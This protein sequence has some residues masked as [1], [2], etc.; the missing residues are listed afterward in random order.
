MPHMNIARTIAEV[1]A[2]VGAARAAGSRVGFVPTMGALHRAHVSLIDA[3][4]RDGAYTVV[5]IFVN[6]TQF[7]PGDDYE[8]YPRTEKQDLDACA[9]AGVDLVFLPGV[10][11]MY[12]PGSVTHIHVET[13]TEHLCGPRRPGHF[14]GVATVV[15]KLFNIVQPD[16]AYF[17]EKDL[18]QLQVIRRMV[19]DLD[20]PITIVGCPTIREPDGLAVSSRNAYLTAAERQQATCLHTALLAARDMILAGERDVGRVTDEIRRVIEAAGPATIEY[21]SV[22]E[23]DTVQPAR[24]IPARAAV[25][26]AVRIGNTR[27]IDN[28]QVNSNADIK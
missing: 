28:I 2:A 18:Q 20:M 27:L 22:V 12:P 15:T 23:P 17:G 4:R 3:A 5:S 7:S 16:V 21:I 13:L 10:E 1:R 6:P 24:I 9:E 11:D 8:R 26:L 14:D 19:R 25:A